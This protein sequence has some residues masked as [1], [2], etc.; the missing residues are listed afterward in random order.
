MSSLQDLQSRQRGEIKELTAKITALRKSIGK[1]AAD[2]KKKQEINEEIVKMQ[3]ELKKKHEMEL[4]AHQESIATNLNVSESQD[5][6]GDY[7]KG[8]R[9]QKR[10]ENEGRS[11]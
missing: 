4:S 2:K 7:K 8:N 9:Q 11:G 3:L 5:L 1:G 6:S 10:R